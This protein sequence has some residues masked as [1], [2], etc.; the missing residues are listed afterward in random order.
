MIKN[1]LFTSILSLC[2]KHEV[3]Y[4]IFK[5]GEVVIDNT[6]NHNL[7]VFAEGFF[8]VWS[9]SIFG[10]SHQVWEIEAPSIIGEGIFFGAFK[11]PVRI[12]TEQD[13]K[14]YI[15]NEN[16]IADIAEDNHH[17]YE[18][19]M[20]ACLAVTTERIREANTERTLWYA[21]VDALE[22][23]SYGN[24]PA[25]LTI[26]KDTFNLEDVIWVERHEILQDVFAIKYK[27]SHGSNPV[28]ERVVIPGWDAKKPYYLSDFIP[29]KYTH[30]YPLCSRDEYFG[31]LLLVT[32]NDRI[33][34]Y[35][36]RIIVDMIP[37]CIRIVESGWKGR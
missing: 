11:K 27:Y 13:G 10:W 1:N 21:L 36:S 8:S 19:L 28:N 20:R 30:V 25:L 22:T 24:I 29:D 4:Q 31:Y 5:A 23:Q 7:Y 9:D 6:T 12:M 3:W 33:P 26:L 34:G 15:L 17:F 2:E 35:I 14:V 37:N 18:I 16:E 32:N